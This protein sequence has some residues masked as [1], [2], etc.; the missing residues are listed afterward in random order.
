MAPSF[1]YEGEHP[2]I[3][4]KTLGQIYVDDC[5]GGAKT[6]STNRRRQTTDP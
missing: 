1:M 6:Q 2:D 3:T 5:I 4:T